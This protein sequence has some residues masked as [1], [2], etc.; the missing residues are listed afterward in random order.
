MNLDFFVCSE[1]ESS[2][3]E[4]F[5]SFKK[6]VCWK[7]LNETRLI[8]FDLDSIQLHNFNESS[9][10]FATQ[11]MSIFFSFFFSFTRCGYCN[12]EIYTRYAAT[13]HNKYKHPGE[14]RYFIKDEQD[15]TKFYVNRAAKK[16]C[17]DENANQTGMMPKCQCRNGSFGF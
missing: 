1:V 13:Y 2:R 4:E 3:H 17:N 5:I 10:H 15:V 9:G 12:E 16:E 11:F 8:L 7:I 6:T 14:P